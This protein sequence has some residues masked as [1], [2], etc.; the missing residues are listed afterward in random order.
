VRR[1]CLE[2]TLRYE[3]AVA[4]SRFGIFGGTTPRERA[5]IERRRRQRIAA[6]AAEP[7]NYEEVLPAIA[8]LTIIPSR[9]NGHSKE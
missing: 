8:L 5:G 9:T 4:S 1:A 2:D 3:R 6:A 7:E